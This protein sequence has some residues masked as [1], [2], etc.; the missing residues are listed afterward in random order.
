MQRE[1][2]IRRSIFWPAAIFAIALASLALAALPGC[3]P[4]PAPPLPP[5]AYEGIRVR[6]AAP[7]APALRQ[8]IQRHGSGWCEQSGA[9]IEI[10][11]S[12]TDADLTTFP[13]AELSAL[14]T[15]RKI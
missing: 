3:F 9:T 7:D 12:G 11:G 14:V 5:R 13:P 1:S 10:V 15:G 2:N 4:G 8:M 6:V